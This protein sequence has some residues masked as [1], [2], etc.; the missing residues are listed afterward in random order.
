MGA[1]VSF[2][3]CGRND[4]Y[5]PSYIRRV[6]RATACL[7]GQ[8]ERVGLDAE[9]IVVEW[10]PPSD[11]P[12]LIESLDLPQKLSRV[13][14]RG[15]IVP[16]EYHDRFAGARERGIQAGE[17][18]NVGLRRA[19][20]RFST[21]KASDTFFS[22]AAIA[23]IA[24]RELDPDTVYRLDRHDVVIED[25]SIW[26]LDD[27]ALLTHLAAL[28]SEIHAFIHQSAYWE[29]RDLHTNACGDF[30][31]MSS[32]YW[33]LLRGGVLD[34]TVLTLDND[35]LVLHAAAALGV[36]ETRW[37]D[38]CRV[39][40]P[41]HGNLNSARVLQVWRPWQRHLD[42][43]L[44]ERV[45]AKAAHWARTSFDYPRRKIRGVESILGPSI[46]RNFVLPASR[47]AQGELPALTQ[48][49]SWGLADVALEQRTLCAADW[50]G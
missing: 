24:Q 30:T 29:L 33:H 10:N 37:P 4:G 31:L 36:I 23:K 2:V 12:L 17:A 26:D 16:P 50:E 6:N 39:Y 28:P 21:T 44:F 45:G 42:K 22:D 18:V 40:K 14:I 46:E 49:E 48:P 5:T 13:A 3:T 43:F 15:I 34:R 7:I 20:G 11:R 47:W 41:I 8:L 1:Y 38:E 9:I 32:A 19:R 27:A 35:S 25:E